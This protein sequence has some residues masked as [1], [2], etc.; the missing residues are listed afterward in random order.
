[1]FL[2][3][4]DT[5]L[6]LLTSLVSTTCL[7]PEAGAAPKSKMAD[8]VAVV[9][10]FI[11]VVVAMIGAGFNSSVMLSRSRFRSAEGSNEVPPE[12]RKS[13]SVSEMP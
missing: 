5:L 8:F 4:F 13:A 1:M 9:A 2:S 3:T 11:V 12:S 6:L 10:S 7:G